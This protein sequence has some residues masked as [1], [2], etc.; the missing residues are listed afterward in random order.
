MTDHNS[1]KP[2]FSS[3]RNY[4][5]FSRQVK[6]NP[7]YADKEKGQAFLASVR[8]TCSERVCTIEK[9]RIFWRAQ[10]GDNCNTDGLKTSFC[11]KRMIPNPEYIGDGRASST[12]VPVLYI[13]SVK[14]A[15]ISETRPWIGSDVSA[16]RFKTVRDLKAIDLTKLFGKIPWEELTFQHLVSWE[17]VY[18]GTAKDAVWCSI[19]NAFSKPVASDQSATDYVPTQILAKLFMDMGYDAIIYRSQ[20]GEDGRNIAVFNVQDAKF[21]DCNLYRVSAIDVKYKATQTSIKS[22][23]QAYTISA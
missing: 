22:Q 9:D 3:W 21:V 13:A 12:G 7:Q 16:A 8:D 11:E 6:R 20:F 4:Y 15:A 5:D 1:G 10:M 19:D 17:E 14:K 18:P 2:T 23:R